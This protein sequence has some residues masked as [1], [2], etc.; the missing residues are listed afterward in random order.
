MIK[1]FHQLEG[2]QMLRQTVI[3][4]LAPTIDTSCQILVLGSMPG[5][6]SQKEAEYY[7][8]P[9][10]LFWILLRPRFR[11]TETRRIKCVWRR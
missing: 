5:A 10:N 8:H 6:I 7:A 3:Y 2:N 4:A 11:L 9:R 1:K